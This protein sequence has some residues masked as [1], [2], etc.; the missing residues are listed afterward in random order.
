MAKVVSDFQT[1]FNEPTPLAAYGRLRVPTL[2]L[3]G[4]TSHLATYAI[5]DHLSAVMPAARLRIVEGAGHMMPL[6]HPEAVG[7]AIVRH[8]DRVAG[9]RPAA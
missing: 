1:V 6:T 3:R 7:S 5:A 8:L 4:E 9:G 2:I